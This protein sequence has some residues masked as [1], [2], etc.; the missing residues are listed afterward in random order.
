MGQNKLIRQDNS[1]TNARYDFTACQ[2]D[3]LFCVMSQIHDEHGSNIY[4]ISAKEIEILTSRKWNYKQFDEATDSLG[5]R[6][7]EIDTNRVYRKYWLFQRV[8]YIKGEGKIEIKFSD[9]G[10]ALLKKLK[11]NFTT[12]ELKSALSMSSKYAKRIYQLCSQWK[13]IGETK[14]YDIKEFKAI[15][16]L[17]DSKGNE[18]YKSISALK[19]YVFDIAVRQINEH[20]DLKVSYHMEGERGRKRPLKYVTF[21][22]KKRSIV[23]L[24]L[25]FQGELNLD[26]RQQNLLL[27]LDEL[28]IKSLKIIDQ[29][30]ESEVMTKIVFEY[31]YGLKTGTITA[32]NPAG[33]LIKKLG[34]S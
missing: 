23:S 27:I 24:P 25:K 34:L 13:D 6:K 11:N 3:I 31:N 28:G 8:D 1:I 5:S 19:K 15:L 22:I 29:I 12:Y 30:K 14:K 33:L 9:E 18:P 17:F 26:I 16:G 10:I 21:Y 20:S 7:F 2:L 4:S 32:K